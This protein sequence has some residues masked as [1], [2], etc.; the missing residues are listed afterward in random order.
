MGLHERE[1]CVRTVPARRGL[2]RNLQWHPQGFRSGLVQQPERR[3]RESQ[4][5]RPVPHSTF[6]AFNTTG[7]GTP[8]TAIFIT[9][10]PAQFQPLT[11]GAGITVMVGDVNHNGIDDIVVGESNGMASFLEASPGQVI[12]WNGDI[13]LQQRTGGLELFRLSEHASPLQYLRRHVGMIVVSQPTPPPRKLPG[14]CGLKSTLRRHSRPQSRCSVDFN[15]RTPH[16]RQSGCL[17]LF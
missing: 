1:R 8:G 12:K 6:T 4:L 5:L 13:H 9:S 15:P 17:A 7:S 14:V 16:V 11:S 3:Q 10:A 2:Q